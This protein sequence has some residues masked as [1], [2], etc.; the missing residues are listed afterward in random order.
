MNIYLIYFRLSHS[1]DINN[2]WVNKENIRRNIKL[3]YVG[4]YDCSFE[5]LDFL[6]SQKRKEATREKEEKEK[7]DKK[8]RKHNRKTEKG[9]KMRDEKV[10]KRERQRGKTKEKN[11]K[12][13]SS[14]KYEIK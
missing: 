3:N 8:E 13:K 4:W 5:I 2:K 11:K 9:G 14:R 6:Y 7:R 10:K 12:H 1:N